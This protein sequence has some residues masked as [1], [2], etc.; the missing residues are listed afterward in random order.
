MENMDGKYLRDSDRF[1]LWQCKCGATLGL[2]AWNGKEIP[3]LMLYRHAVDLN[4][5]SPADVDTMG[6]LTGKMVVRCDLCE[7]VRV[8]WPSAQAML[9]LLDELNVDQL[10][11]FVEAFLERKRIRE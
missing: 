7:A 5:D 10:R 2:V 8:W 6:P 3:Q 1:K 4:A 9:S 11:Q